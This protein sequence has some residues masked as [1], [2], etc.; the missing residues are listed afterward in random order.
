MKAVMCPSFTGPD[1]LFVGDAPEPRPAAD[2]VLV[3]VGAASVTYMD[4]LLVS[5]KYQMRPRTPFI[6]GTEAAGTVIAVGERVTRFR[7]GDRVACDAWH[8]AHAE[9]MVAKEYAAARIP[10]TVDCVPA[11]TVLHSYG[12]AHYALVD[13]A[14]LR[15]G[16]TV[17]VTGA[18]GGLGL[19]AIEIAVNLG[20]RAIAGVGADEKSALVREHGAHDVINYEKDDLRARLTELTRG[21]GVDVC[22]DTL[23]GRIFQEMARL[24]RWGGRLLPIGFTSGEIPTVPMNLPLLKNYAIVGVFYGAWNGRFPVE[25]AAM[26]DQLMRWLGD[27]KIRPQVGQVVAL[28]GVKDAMRAIASRSVT[29]RSV[30]RVGSDLGVARS[31]P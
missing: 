16:E 20:A 22:F 4:Y 17:F 15:S 29:G 6:P 28:D 13:R 26:G 19:A 3:E 5:G 14:Q 11:A 7:P 21:E 10:D 2:E 9:R 8:G 1:D 23:G 12:S 27:G 18:A 25:R 30:V 24:M 31:E